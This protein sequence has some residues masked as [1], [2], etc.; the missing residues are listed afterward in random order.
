MRKDWESW[1]CSAW[2][3]E[4]CRETLKQLPVPEGACGKDGEKIFSRA[5]CDRQ[6]AMALN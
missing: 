1:G 5:C 4:G 6:G 3:R 2:G